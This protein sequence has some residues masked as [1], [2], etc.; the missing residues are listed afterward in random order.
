MTEHRSH[1][2]EVASPLRI[3]MEEENRKFEK[4]IV[5]LPRTN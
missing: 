2:E 4:S 3:W 5:V 1:Q